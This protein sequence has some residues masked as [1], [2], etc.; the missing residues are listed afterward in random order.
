M[1]LG[2]DLPTFALNFSRPGG[3]IIA[4]YYTLLRLGRAG[5]RRIY[6]AA[7]DTARSLA[8]SIADLGPFTLLY[9]GQGALPAVSYKLTDPATADFSLYDLTD[10]LRR[11]GW[12][13]PSYPL[14]PERDDTVVQ[15]VLVR[16]GI[17]R[18]TIALLAGDIRTAV[19]R[20]G[21]GVGTGTPVQP[22]FHH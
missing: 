16:H 22:G 20:L 15:R 6:Q 19:A 1:N 9:D 17:S 4:Q 5:Y 11:R 14:P 13:V 12:Q 3:E 7:S 2:G 10:Q 8:R 18:D 21:D